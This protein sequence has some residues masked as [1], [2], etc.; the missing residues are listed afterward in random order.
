[1]KLKGDL[2]GVRA[3]K[4]LPETIPAG[5]DCPPELEEAARTLGLIEDR[6]AGKARGAAP[7]NKAAG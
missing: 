3:G 2:F 4:V 1:M 6:P 5:A 7:E